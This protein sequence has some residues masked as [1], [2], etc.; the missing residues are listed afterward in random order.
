MIVHHY[1]LTQDYNFITAVNGNKIQITIT[2]C[3]RISKANMIL[4]QNFQ[5]AF[6]FSHI[7]NIAFSKGLSYFQQQILSSVTQHLTVVFLFQE[8]N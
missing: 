8:N 6:F 5:S 3:Q 2:P 7:N 1:T 4:M